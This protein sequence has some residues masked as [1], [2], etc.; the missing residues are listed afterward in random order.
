MMMMMQRK[1]DYFCVSNS[2]FLKAQALLSDVL[3]KLCGDTKQQRENDH[4]KKS[5]NA[6][7][8]ERVC[9]KTV[10]VKHLFSHVS[11]LQLVRFYSFS[12]KHARVCVCVCVCRFKNVV[13]ARTRFGRDK[14]V[15]LLLSLSVCLQVVIFRDVLDPAFGVL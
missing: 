12:L 6:C 7:I 9:T 14:A 5:N 15:L 10:A 2:L 13:R 4:K 1:P 11:S 8:K 3:Q